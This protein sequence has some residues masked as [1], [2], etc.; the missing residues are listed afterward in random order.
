[1]SMTSTMSWRRPAGWFLLSTLLAG[2]CDLSTKGWAQ[3]TLGPR[4]GG[5]MSVVDPW[6]EFSLA[7]NRGTAFSLIPDLDTLRVVFGALSVV[8]FVALLVTA[9][10]RRPFHWVP[11]LTMGVIA[12]GALGNGYDRVFRATPAGEPAVV[13]FIRVN[14]TTAYSW[15]TFNLADVWLVVGVAVL[16]VWSWRVRDGSPPDV[17]LA[18]G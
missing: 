1:M 18:A 6:L 12:G 8:V 11:V 17:A 4:P 15:P 2:G 14:L 13:D 10:R 16:L 5:S 7:Y 9:V 3:Q